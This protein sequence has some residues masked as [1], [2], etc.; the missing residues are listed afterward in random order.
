MNSIDSLI[1]AQHQLELQREAATERLAS[2][3]V[4]TGGGPRLGP[5]RRLAGRSARGLSWALAAL[6]ARVD[7]IEVGRQST[8]NGREGRLT[9]SQAQ[10]G[11]PTCLS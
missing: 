4:Q 7:P 6:A 9:A 8:P 10:E 11:T 1:V 3:A 2:E 5:V